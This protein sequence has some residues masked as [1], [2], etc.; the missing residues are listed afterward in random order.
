VIFTI[1]GKELKTLFLSPLAWAILTVVQAI[2]AYFFLVYLDYYVQIQ[3]Q[4]TQLPNAPGV[5]NMVVVPLFSTVAVVVLLVVPLLTMR[6]VSEE[7]R[8][9]TLTLLISAPVS[10]T[11]IIM[12]KFTGLMAF[13]LIMLGLITLMPLSLL[14]AGSIDMGL[15]FSGILAL[16]LLLCS[17]AALGLYV[18]T[19]T[20]Q[21]TV[22]AIA[23][24][25]ILLLLW[26]LDLAGKTG[27]EDSVLAYLSMLNHYQS[28]LRGVFSSADVMYYLLFIAVFLILSV[29]HLDAQRLQQ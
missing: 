7:R 27:G 19:L 21:P 28:L 10:I 17:F 25:G 6:L 14:M 9:Q 18:S 20:S 2:L 11:Q 26:I 3:P 24:F 29:R 5:T 12:G 22:A 4:L 23:T 15:L 1:A 8:N 13:L 16:V